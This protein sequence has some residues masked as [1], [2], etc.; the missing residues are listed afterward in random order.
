[1][2]YPLIW[3][4]K[5]YRALI[6][7]LYGEVCRYHPS[8]SAYAL[9]AVSRHGAVRGSWLALRRVGRCHPWAEGGVDL[10]PPARGEPVAATCDSEHLGADEF[11][12]AS[13]TRP[14]ARTP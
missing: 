9:E 11:R 3:F 7:P 8:C 6:S 13:T 4:L 10:V 12:R 14:S 5:A 2:K 1:V